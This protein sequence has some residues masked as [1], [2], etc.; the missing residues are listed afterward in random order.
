MTKNNQSVPPPHGPPTQP[1]TPDSRLT[2]LT[3][4]R[5]TKTKMKQT[6]KTKKKQSNMRSF[7]KPTMTTPTDH[8]NHDKDKDNDKDREKETNVNSPSWA[9]RVNAGTSKNDSVKE[10]DLTSD[11]NDTDDDTNK[12]FKEVERPRKRSKE[13]RQAARSEEESESDKSPAKKTV[14]FNKTNK[15]FVTLRV[16]FTASTFEARQDE[17]R[18]AINKTWGFCYS[19]K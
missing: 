6:T 10:V 7:A 16:K 11:T 14:R 15:F 2:T 13:Q 17:A 18:E 4:P 19:I 12:G 1:K 3:N 5:K 9:E 8:T